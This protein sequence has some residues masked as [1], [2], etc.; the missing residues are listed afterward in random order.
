MRDPPHW[1]MCCHLFS[2]PTNDKDTWARSNL[3]QRCGNYGLV[4]YSDVMRIW[5]NL[6]SMWLACEWC[7]IRNLACVLVPV[8]I[9]LSSEHHLRI[10]TLL[11]WCNSWTGTTALSQ[12][13]RNSY[14]TLIGQQLKNQKFTAKQFKILYRYCVYKELEYYKDITDTQYKGHKV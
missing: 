14:R 7:Q 1:S 9:W 8:D 4:R 12:I 2:S 5:I 3:M 10:I 11:I 6:P 13:K